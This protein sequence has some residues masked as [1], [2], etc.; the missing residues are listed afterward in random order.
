MQKQDGGPNPTFLQRI[1]P[2]FLITCTTSGR[3]A[4]WWKSPMQIILQNLVSALSSYI[5]FS[6]IYIYIIYI[7]VCMYNSDMYCKFVS[8]FY[9]TKVLG[10]LTVANAPRLKAPA[11]KA[12]IKT[13]RKPRLRDVEVKKTTKSKSFDGTSM[14]LTSAFLHMIRPQLQLLEQN[15]QL[16]QIRRQRRPRRPRTSLTVPTHQCTGPVQNRTQ[17]ISTNYHEKND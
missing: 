14:R 10:I 11:P 1:R 13:W 3:L 6:Y 4:P 5:I 16:L 12:N 9:L 7:Y 17:Q 15:V 2:Y 8:H